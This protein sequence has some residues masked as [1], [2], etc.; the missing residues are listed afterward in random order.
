MNYTNNKLFYKKYFVNSKKSSNFAEQLRVIPQH[1]IK[2]SSL[3]QLVRA[4]DC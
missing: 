3:A 2:Y 1:L 4:S